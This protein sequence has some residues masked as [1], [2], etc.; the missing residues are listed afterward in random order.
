MFVGILFFAAAVVD[1]VKKNGALT[2]Y[3]VVRV[4]AEEWTPR[5]SV[6]HVLKVNVYYQERNV[7]AKFCHRRTKRKR[8]ARRG[9]D[10][11]E[12]YPCKWK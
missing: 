5:R 12:I 2:F 3:Q 7:L 9:I 1:V 11:Q 6:A 10:L 4:V 8:I